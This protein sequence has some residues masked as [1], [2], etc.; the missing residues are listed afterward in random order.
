LNRPTGVTIIA[1]LSFLGAFIMAIIAFA[2]LA[3]GALIASMG[4]ALPASLVGI[5]AVVAAC[6]FLALGI[7]YVFNGIGL[8]KLQ[9][10]ARIL[11]IV[12]I[13]L[14]LLSAALG[15]LSGLFHFRFLLLLR[16][17]CV[18][19]IDLSILSYL[20]KPHVKQ[21]FGTTGF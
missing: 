12:L 16:E 6:F 17:I 11:T 2:F 8:L 9:N 3:G 13:G 5:G 1:V 14:G 21:A 19:A 15:I 7:L 18:A 4:M 10:W 20:F